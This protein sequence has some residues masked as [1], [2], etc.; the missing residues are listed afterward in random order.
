MDFF[1]NPED[2][3]G[4]VLERDSAD[5]AATR[6]MEITGNEDQQDIVETCEKIFGSEEDTGQQA[7]ET[8][9]SVLAKYNLT[10]LT[11]ESSGIN[12][13]TKE[14]QIMRQPGEY[15][16]P[17]RVCP[18]LPYSVGKRLIS[19]YNCR[20]Y[21]LDSLVLDDTP[22]KVY[23]METL[24]RRHMMDKFAREFKNDE[25]KWVGGYI[26]ERFQVFHND[27]GNQMELPNGE[28]TR[29]P[30]PHQYSTERRLEEGRGEKTYDIVASTGSKVI[31]LAANDKLSKEASADNEISEI[32]GDIIEMRDAGLTDEAIL[33]QVSDH[34]GLPIL[35]V[36]KIQK[37]AYRA[38]NRHGGMVYSYNSTSK[39]K[40]A[41][42]DYPQEHT[43]WASRVDPNQTVVVDSAGP[44]GVQCHTLPD[45][46]PLMVPVNSFS[47]DYAPLDPDTAENDTI[48]DTAR[49]LGIDENV[50]QQPADAMEPAETDFNIEN[51]Q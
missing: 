5:E 47:S 28:R 25:G 3:K 37:A 35:A 48:V 49:E 18:K 1:V 14:A 20:H 16:M 36:A 31:K 51:V 29:K 39:I 19:T 22:D 26:N 8:L 40:T 9:F 43:S 2:L 34:Y 32:F 21:C 4:W 10:S 23:C 33:G 17:L 11:K 15:N 41:S 38:V 13:L 7:A 6:I 46:Q 44:E 50:E 30:R 27:G 45:G 42:L 12:R 24:W